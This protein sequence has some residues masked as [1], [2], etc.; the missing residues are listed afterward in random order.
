MTIEFVPYL[1]T[2]A[3]ACLTQAN[4]HTLGIEYG[5]CALAHM[6]VKPG[7]AFWNSG[8]N[9]ATY[10]AWDKALIL[11]AS[12]LALNAQA[13]FI[14]QSPY[15]G[16]RVRFSMDE[17]WT[18]VQQ[19]KPNM[20]LISRAEAARFVIDSQN[21]ERLANTKIYYIDPNCNGSRE[22]ITRRRGIDCPIDQDAICFTD[23]ERILYGSDQPAQDALAGIVYQEHGSQSILD[24]Q[25]SLAFDVLDAECGCTTCQQKFTGAYL[26]HLFQSTPLLCQRLLMMHNMFWIKNAFLSASRES[27]L[28]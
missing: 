11:D 19:M 5:L 1:T 13:Q 21:S 3:G 23:Q 16:S 20:L 18:L 12:S 15:D 28:R 4:W 8:M 25:F 22:Q 10:L 6:V 2:P 26:H 7:L 17:F 27:H 9:L 14:V 24:K